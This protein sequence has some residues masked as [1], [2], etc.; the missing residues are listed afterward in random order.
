MRSIV[1]ECTNDSAAE[2][3]DSERGATLVLAAAVLLVLMGMAGFAVDL[4][5]L[6]SQRTEVK[7]AAESAALAGVVH[8]P[9]G[10][11]ET[12]LTSAAHDTALDVASRLGYQ[13]DS[14]GTVVPTEV[15][16]Q[17]TQLNVAVSRNVQTF[18]MSVF[19]VDSVTL[20]QDAT[21]EYIKPLP[22]G[23]PENQ[24]G[25]DP[26]CAPNLGTETDCANFWGNIHGKYT[27]NGMGDAYSSYCNSGNGSG[28]T[29]NP[30]WRESGYVFAVEVPVDTTVT[31]DIVDP[32]FVQ[33][34][35]NSI[36]AGDNPI[37]GNEGPTTRF[38]LYERVDT[39]S[40]S[41]TG[42]PLCQ[43][44]YAP[45]P[46]GTPFEWRHF[47]TRTVAAGIY[48][49]RVEIIGESY[50]LN[51]WSLRATSPSAQQPSIYAVG[52]M[53]I[54]AN[55]NA[56]E[57]EF[58]LAEVLPANAGK[59]M[60][61]D[62]FDPGEANGD[63]EI[64]IVGPDGSSPPCHLV[65]PSDGVDQNLGQ[66]IIDTT[67]PAH[68]YHDDWLFVEIDLPDSYTCTDC[69]WTIVYDYEGDATDTTTWTA[70]MRGNPIRLLP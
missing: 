12:F 38:T 5:W 17:P 46:V 33:G 57:T 37:N 58:Y 62:L 4:G 18:F 36:N 31:V 25:N 10:A 26:G 19:G 23:S 15:P 30:R 59:T 41:F 28:C 66:C 22:L 55:V 16:G 21:A 45:E 54:Y 40:Q 35:G 56:G 44:D 67:R 47:C 53:S 14:E 32:A 64:R 20:D 24:F 69:W 6:Y 8:M 29:I 34:G 1:E 51:R 9:I 39:L 3:R 43:T 60:E 2:G 52:D 68:N 7:K 48:P 49:L 42:T 27:D 63:N 11:S 50:G 70:R 61:I 13:N 65:I